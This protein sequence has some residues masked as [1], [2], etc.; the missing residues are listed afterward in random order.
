MAVEKSMFVAFK[1]KYISKHQFIL[2]TREMIEQ[3]INKEWGLLLKYTFSSVLGL[4]RNESKIYLFFLS[5]NH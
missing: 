3:K 1:K 4:L 2:F 5:Q